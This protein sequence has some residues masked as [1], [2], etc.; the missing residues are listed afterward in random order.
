MNNKGSQLFFKLIAGAGIGRV[1]DSPP[2]KQIDPSRL[3]KLLIAAMGTLNAEP[4]FEM[5][6]KGSTS[7]QPVSVNK[8][9]LF[10]D[11]TNATNFME[12][13]KKNGY[14]EVALNVMSE[15]VKKMTTIIKSYNGNVDDILPETL[16]VTFDSDKVVQAINAVLDMQ[17][18]L[19]NINKTLPKELE[20]YRLRHKIGMHIGD[21]DAVILGDPEVR[22]KVCYA[23]DDMNLCSRLESANKEYKTSVT[24]SESVVPSL[25]KLG[26]IVYIPT[27]RVIV[28]GKTEPV[29]IYSLL[30]KKED[31]KNEPEKIKA[32]EMYKKAYA[33]EHNGDY[34]Q[35][36]S[37]YRH[38]LDH[39]NNE[40][41]ELG[42]QY[43]VNLHLE[44]SLLYHKAERVFSQML[45]YWHHK[46]YERAVNAVDDLTG[47]NIDLKKVL[48]ESE[49][50]K[51]LVRDCKKRISG[52]RKFDPAKYNTPT[53]AMTKLQSGVSWISR[54]S[55]LS[56]IE[57]SK[58]DNFK[59][60]SLLTVVQE[61][62]NGS[63]VY[64]WMITE[65]IRVAR[66][67]PKEFSVDGLNPLQKGIFLYLREKGSAVETAKDYHQAIKCLQ[68]ALKESGNKGLIKNGI[69]EI[70]K[71]LGRERRKAH[72]LAVQ[73]QLTLL[74]NDFIKARRELIARL[75]L[76]ESDPL[77]SFLRR[78]ETSCLHTSYKHKEAAAVEEL[79]GIIEKRTELQ[80]VG[81][82]MIAFYES[83]IKMLAD[84]KKAKERLRDTDDQLEKA[85]SGIISG[86]KTARTRI[87]KIILE[88]E[89]LNSR[90]KI[91]FKD[92]HLRAPWIKLAK[93]NDALLQEFPDDPVGINLK[94]KIHDRDPDITAKTQ[95]SLIF[96]AVNLYFSIFNNLSSGETDLVNDSRA[97]FL[98][99]RKMLHGNSEFLDLMFKS[100]EDMKPLKVIYEHVTKLT[101]K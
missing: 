92:L 19:V 28:K 89:K 17:A 94:Q 91:L 51:V 35:A 78:E 21:T 66:Q 56:R 95:D 58:G 25:D 4:V 40:L 87:K 80:A 34:Q 52:R 12:T 2:V 49:V 38:V 43:L 67:E 97:K 90:V 33:L 55:D 50:V 15:Y 85:Y 76:R 16:V 73:E 36:I 29:S 61:C 84:I 48:M 98:A 7:M 47:D 54:W 83:R 11:L 53:D 72:Y 82:K 27:D 41:E 13:A 65:M 70:R 39:N 32:I 69:N 18:E 5:L 62:F 100:A 59:A 88:Q 64:N 93:L 57:P 45:Y 23:S 79:K 99:I 86:D 26:N 81:K 71:A 20:E 68:I 101:S 77:I 10:L 44:R 1:T 63:E 3:R 75:N 30:C 37:S 14:R 96:K 60:V 6:E 22:F 8:A 31:I 24:V 42:I 46:Q 74:R 9:I